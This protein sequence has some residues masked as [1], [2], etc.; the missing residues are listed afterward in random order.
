MWGIAS[1]DTGEEEV[2]I[3]STNAYRYPPKI[4]NYFGSHFYM[5]GERFDMS[6]P[7]SYLFGEN[8][9]LNFLGN[10]PIPFPY[11]VS[12]SGSE[13][14][15]PLKSLLN[16]RK[17]SLKFVK[18]DDSGDGSGG[19]KTDSINTKY[20]IE[21]TFDSDSKCA[22][23]VY[24]FATEDVNNGQ[25]T[26]QSR[27]P[28]L[29]SETY[30]YKRGANQLFSQPTH[31]LD[32]SKF[33]DEEWQYDPVKETIP[34][35]ISCVVEDDDHP[36][37]CHLT[38]AVV[39]KSSVDGGYMI[40][41][42][43]QKQFVDGLIYLL[44]EIYGIENKHT[45]R[46]KLEDPDDEVEDSGAEC[47]ICMSDMRD[48]L[49]LPCRHLCLC[50]NCAESLRYQASS[51]PICRSPFRALL[52]IRAMR[53]KQ[54]LSVQTGETG[55][56]NPVSQEGVPTGY[57]ALSLIEAVNGP[58]N[59]LFTVD[60][61]LQLPVRTVAP[62]DIDNSY[63]EKKRLSK[64]HVIS[65]KPEEPVV[66]PN[67]KPDDKKVLDEEEE[68]RKKDIPVE[69][70]RMERKSS[71][72]DAAKSQ[73]TENKDI[74]DE[75]NASKIVNVSDYNT[76]SLDS[77]GMRPASLRVYESEADSDYDIK[78]MTLNQG[79]PSTENL[80]DD[81]REDSSEPEAEPEPDYEDDLSA[82]SHPLLC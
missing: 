53:K 25:I 56:E 14:T 28:C 60:G 36:C 63:R 67:V 73:Y 71:K 16:I 82:V 32:P 30:H 79:H 50:S 51:C 57:E 81:E 11:Q 7:E 47:V 8:S 41:A 68:E 66:S 62:G 33:S 77:K 43:K 35:I 70:V 29:N 69:V 78:P 18:V 65:V 42:L 54:P 31:V 59:Q 80:A 58:C 20:N 17:D 64:R 38:Y 61:G 2:D 4:G 19:D 22:I 55:E 48:T 45:D 27:E 9:D 24:Y 21:F 6:Q 44:Q 13:P 75:S 46:S 76:D 74:S 26:F 34:V 72:K 10:K 15:K 5:G 12:S 3:A 49:I 40:K 1:R 39:E 37:H 23:T 52:Q